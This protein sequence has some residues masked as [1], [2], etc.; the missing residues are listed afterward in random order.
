MNKN[1]SVENFELIVSE[2]MGVKVLVLTFELDDVKDVP[3]LV[4]SV[5]LGSDRKFDV[6]FEDKSDWMKVSF[7]DV[8]EDMMDEL[9]E[10]SHITIAC[11]DDDGLVF[12]GLSELNFN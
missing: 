7:P 3:R 6:V 1:A 2:H 5:S 4:S 9:K 8:P 12:S 10:F 11:L